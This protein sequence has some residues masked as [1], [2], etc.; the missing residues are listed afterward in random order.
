MPPL[1]PPIYA[2]KSD[3]QMNKRDPVDFKVNSGEEKYCDAIVFL[4]VAC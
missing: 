4:G 2:L 1:R 3:F